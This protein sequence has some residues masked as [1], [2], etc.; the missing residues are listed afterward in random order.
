MANG[1]VSKVNTDAPSTSDS[2]GPPAFPSPASSDGNGKLWLLHAVWRQATLFHDNAF[3]A[4]MKHLE[5]L[6]NQVYREL[7]LLV[8]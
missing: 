5:F 3:Q 8:Q 7:H 1:F 6:S 2:N 4:Q